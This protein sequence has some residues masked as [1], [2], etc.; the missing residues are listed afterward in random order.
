MTGIRQNGQK[1]LIF[2]VVSQVRTKIRVNEKTT[3]QQ[4]ENELVKGKYTNIYAYVY[5]HTPTDIQTYINTDTHI[6]IN[7]CY[8]SKIVKKFINHSSI[9]MLW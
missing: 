8:S 5:K 7:T 9:K 4:H 3:H 1:R 6:H 2:F